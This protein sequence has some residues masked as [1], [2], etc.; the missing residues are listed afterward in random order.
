[1]WVYSPPFCFICTEFFWSETSDFFQVWG[2]L[3]LCLY[4]LFSIF[5]L[6]LWAVFEYCAS[7]TCP[8]C[9][10]RSSTFSISVTLFHIPGDFLDFI[11]SPFYWCIFSISSIIYNFSL[12]LIVILVEF[13][14]YFRNRTFSQISS[15]RSFL[16]LFH[17]LFIL[18]IVC[19]FLGSVFP[20]SCSSIPMRF[21]LDSQLLFKT[22]GLGS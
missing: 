1:M 6:R 22:E 10:I 9:C 13:C 15:M 21:L 19:F 4:N 20:L 17:G 2:I 18:W 8:L 3:F 7:W 12:A 14:F 16:F 11:F 5:F